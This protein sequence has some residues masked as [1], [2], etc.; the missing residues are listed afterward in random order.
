[1][2]FTAR[3]RL[4]QRSHRLLPTRQINRLDTV[5][6]EIDQAERVRFN[7]PHRVMLSVKHSTRSG[8]TLVYA[9]NLCRPK[10]LQGRGIMNL[11]QP[12]FTRVRLS[13]REVG[14]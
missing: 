5:V 9:A 6:Q 14:D 11:H 13:L 2:V 1:M 10:H 7:T 8:Y 12:G 3:S 4:T